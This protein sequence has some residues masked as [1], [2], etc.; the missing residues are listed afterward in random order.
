MLQR[1]A[2]LLLAVLVASSSVASSI[3]SACP[4]AG[5]QVAAS[6][7]PDRIDHA[8]HAT[9]EQGGHPADCA[10]IAEPPMDS[11]MGCCAGSGPAGI[12][13]A[14]DCFGAKAEQ[15]ERV[16]EAPS[17]FQLRALGTAVRVAPLELSPSRVSSRLTA[18]VALAAAPPETLLAQH[19]SL[20]R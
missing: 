11:P 4:M 18:G 10:R 14:I 8:A 1:V 2:V 19:T 17:S 15:A 20:L 16:A 3:C 5:A 6:A 7:E 9:A 12:A 13:S